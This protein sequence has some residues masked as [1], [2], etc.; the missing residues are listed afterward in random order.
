MKN[1]LGRFSMELDSYLPS[2]TPLDGPDTVMLDGYLLTNQGTEKPFSLCSEALVAQQQ[3][4][5]LA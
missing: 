4:R 1:I 5:G 3:R 2:L